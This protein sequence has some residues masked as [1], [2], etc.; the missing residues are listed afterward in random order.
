VKYTDV[1]HFGGADDFG[2]F[3]FYGGFT[4]NAF[5]DFL[6]GLPTLTYYAV[7][8]P[9]LVSPAWRYGVYGQDEFQV[10][11]KLTISLGLR[12]EFNPPFDEANGNI[13]NFDRATNSIITP[14]RTLPP[15]QAFLYSVNACPGVVD[16]LPCSPIVTASQ[17]HLPSGLRQNYLRNFAPRLS[18]AYRPFGDDKT[19]FRGGVGVFTQ[20]LT[21][22]SAYVL[23]GI[24]ATDTE[25]F[26][27]S[28]AN[29][30][31]LYQFPA[32]SAGSSISPALAGTGEF[33][34]AQDP[35]FRDPSSLQWNVTVERE[36]PG[37][38]SF[39]ASYIG[40]N[41]YRLPLIVDLNQVHPN[42]TGYDPSQKPYQ[43]WGRV[44][45]LDNVAFA[46]YQALQLEFNHRSR[47]GLFLQTSYTLAKNLT[48]ANGDTPG[49][50]APEYGAIV[51]DR[52]DQSANRGN[53]PGTRRHRF[54]ATAIYELPIGRGARFLSGLNTGWNAALGGWLL[55]TITLIE[56]GPYLTPTASAAGDPANIN[57]N[58]RLISVIRPDVVGTASGNV[59]DPTSDHW[60]DINAFTETPANS[61]RLGNA[62]VG[63]L[64]GPGTVTAAVGLAKVF[65]LTEHARLRFEASFTNLFNHPNFAPPQTN[66]SNPATFGVINSVQTAENSGNRIGQVELRLE[67]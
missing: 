52:F 32:A 24:H 16:T 44:L 13:T 58:G 39:R 62:G 12:W 38:S 2:D 46:N 41:S 15:S 31:P 56:T 48:N 54:L 63:T 50:F 28:D 26:F 36:L 64:L 45:S 9:D 42:T 43:N 17:E 51:T 35:H 67:F 49:G 55:S 47:K 57:T 7:T 11:R 10:N 29:G 66:I 3:P 30:L 33:I 65:S 25:L 59:S 4:G 34:V 8:G 61:G 5:A 27:N 22:S 23:T 1:Q 20:A 53:D 37:S 40:M 19:V 60:F 18:V 6:E 21:G 14:D